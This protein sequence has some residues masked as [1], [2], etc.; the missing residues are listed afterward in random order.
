MDRGRRILY[1]MCFVGQETKLN[2]KNHSSVGRNIKI[3][4]TKACNR[5]HEDQ[6]LDLLLRWP[7]L[8]FF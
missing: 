8:G 5:S 7:E 4:Q 6:P 1:M 2:V 3:M